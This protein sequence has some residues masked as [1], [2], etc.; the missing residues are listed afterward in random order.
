VLLPFTGLYT[1]SWLA[2][3][4]AAGQPL[5]AA[6]VVLGGQLATSWI[7]AAVA[8]GAFA[9]KAVDSTNLAN[10][11]RGTWVAGAFATVLLGTM[12]AVSLVT[13]CV[14]GGCTDVVGGISAALV[15]VI[16]EAQVLVSSLVAWRLAR[17]VGS[18]SLTGSEPSLAQR[19][20]APQIASPRLLAGDL[21]ASGILVPAMVVV[22]LVQTGTYMPE[23]Y[24]LGGGPER[25]LV[26]PAL[27]HGAVLAVCWV[28][29]ALLTGAFEDKVAFGEVGLAETIKR[30]SA[31]GAL[32]AVL[33]AGATAL[34]LLATAG[35]ERLADPNDIDA[36]RIASRAFFDFLVDVPLEAAWVSLW[37]LGYAGFL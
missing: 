18:A 24:I 16:V 37:R 10:T 15:D 2:A 13:A 9:E 1:P 35:P 19:L 17:A 36:A 27:A 34:G 6:F 4:Y 33:S 7:F 22:F 3:F 26:Q 20:A 25:G 21:V 28:N 30:L 8:T 23:W 32:A 14:T 11:L 29:A 31:A 5:P 12:A